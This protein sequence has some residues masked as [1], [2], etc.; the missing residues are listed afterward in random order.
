MAPFIGV[1]AISRSQNVRIN[2]QKV[3]ESVTTYVDLNPATAGT[4]PRAYPPVKELRSHLALGAL[5]V[6]VPLTYTASDWAVK[7]GV[8]TTATKAT[9]PEVAVTAGSVIQRSTGVETAVEALAAKKEKSTVASKERIDII[10]ANESKVEKAAFKEGV[11][12]PTGAAVQPET[13]EEEKLVE[14]AEKLA[15]AEITAKEYEEKVTALAKE[16]VVATITWVGVTET[17]TIVLTNRA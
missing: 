12:A 1:R 13:V 6:V 8:Q 14:Y 4:F 7:Y 5:I 3:T 10:T 15:K 17:P 11:A 9:E 16:V 2:G